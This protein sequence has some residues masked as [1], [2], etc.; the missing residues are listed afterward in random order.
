[1][2]PKFMYIAGN[3]N[4]IESSCHLQNQQSVNPKFRVLSITD[5]ELKKS[6]KQTQ[7]KM[8]EIWLHRI[9]LFPKTNGTVFVTL[10]AG[11]FF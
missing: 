7:T 10:L 11:L 1:M 6:Y 9:I 5:N 4:N 8:N 3:A 2:F